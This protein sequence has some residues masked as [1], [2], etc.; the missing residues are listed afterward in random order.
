MAQALQSQGEAL[1]RMGQSQKMI[2]LS[3]QAREL[4]VSAGDPRGAARTLLM[5]G[6]LLYDQ[7]DNEGA[8]KQFEAALPVFREIGN[9]ASPSRHTRAHR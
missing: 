1:E 7:G 4:F 5:V 3:S 6:D 8:K 2:E 9:L